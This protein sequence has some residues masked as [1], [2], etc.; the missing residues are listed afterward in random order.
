MKHNRRSTD[1][2]DWRNPGENP[3]MP[4]GVPHRAWQEGYDGKPSS[5]P[6]GSLYESWYLQGAAAAAYDAP[7]WFSRLADWLWKYITNT[8]TNTTGRL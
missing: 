2:P 5:S 7:S 1:A 6:A 3:H 8:N 4:G